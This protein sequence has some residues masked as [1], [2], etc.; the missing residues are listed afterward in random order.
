MYCYFCG[1]EQPQPVKSKCAV[2]G[3]V[4]QLPPSLVT[5]GRAYLLNRLP[6][7]TEAGV[8]DTATAERIREVVGDELDGVAAPPHPLTPATVPARSVAA[9]API[10]VREPAAVRAAAPAP[11]G[12]SF[13]ETFFTPERAPSLL[14]YLGAFLVVV[15]ALIFVNVSGQQISDA[16]RLVLMIVGTLGFLAGGLVCH[17]IPRVAEAG[18]TFLVVG[19]LLVPLDFGAYY[20][21]IARVSPFTSP[22]MWVLGSLVTAGLYGALAIT[23]YGRAYSY[24]FFIASLSALGGFAVLLHLL[25]AWSLV[26]FAALPLAIQLAARIGN[27]RLLRL[28]GP[29]DRPGQFLMFAALV[30]GALGTVVI[31]VSRSLPLNERLAVPALALLVTAYYLA[32]TDR[33]HPRERW[34]AAAGPAAIVF[35]SLVAVD[36]PAQTYGF[37][38]GLLA[39][40]YALIREV[41]DLSGAP[42]PFPMWARDRARYLGYALIA[43]AFLPVA[44]YWRAPF[45][46]A[47]TYVAMA[48][49]LGSLAVWRA[50]P[51]R[52]GPSPL[53]VSGLA[54]VGAAALHIGVIFVLVATGVTRSGTAPFSGLEPR[55]IALGFV[56]IAAVLGAL[57]LIS[58]RRV[59]SLENAVSLAGLASAV[60]VVGLSFR[61]APLATVLA[62]AASVG[63]AIAAVDGRRPPRLWIAA[64]FAAVAA[65]SA[66]RWMQPPEELR[67]LALAA[68]ALLLFAPAYLGR[69][70][71]NA[72]ARVVRE[73]AIAAAL[74]AVGV[75]F[76]FALARPLSVVPWD[77]LVWL[78]T[79]PAFSVFGALAFIEGLH[80]R[81]ERVALFATASFLA[82]VLIVVARLHPAAIEAYTLPAAIY[83]GLAAWGIAR[84]GSRALRADLGL[85]AQLGAAVALLGPTYLWSWERDAVS[86]T[87]VVLAESVILLR[88]ASARGL[89]ELAAVSIGALGLV[90]VRAAAA[91]LALE[92]STAAFGAIT[93]ALVLL[94]PR[95]SW[96]VGDRLRE[97]AEV[98]GVLLLLGP[99]LVRA[100]AFGADALSHGASVL[101]GGAVVVAFGLWSGRRA[102]VATAAA[103]LAA[104]GVLALRDAARAESFVAASGVVVLALV[105]AIP[106]YLPRRLPAIYEMALEILA[107]GLVVSGGIEQ[108]LTA[109]LSGGDGHAARVLA[110]SIVLLAIGLA[111]SRRALA[112]AGLAAVAVM[113]IWIMGDPTARQFHGIAAGA[114][115]IGISL[116]A[117]RYAPR[118][119]SDRA[120][121]GSELLG[122]TLFLAPTLL[123]SWRAPFVPG[124]IIVFFEIALLLAV[125][126]LLR[127]RWLVAG[128]LAVVGLEAIRGTIDVVNRLPNWALF[129]GSGAI[130][131]TAGFVLLL[132]REAWNEWSRRAYA[133]WARL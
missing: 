117:V 1:A 25:P 121:I 16:V 99:P 24:L 40:A 66:G 8:V 39:I 37:V 2:C 88:F 97:A 35:G 100:T 60:L 102:V 124:T 56:P 67:P 73:I 9:V 18:P 15:A 72:F 107:V 30:L 120:L 43:G 119:L 61:E 64:A 76:T 122:A 104:T 19:A 11:K 123:A 10:A 130:L 85:L 22:A 20:A 80:R 21:L 7:L 93:L 71:E 36:A 32:R 53:D 92:S 111:S 50:W 54:M 112:T 95:I 31:A 26:P 59:P 47:T 57:A 116:A 44:A 14:L 17:R 6:D 126:I 38:S 118:V 3:R 49:L 128:A 52:R 129:G 109:R 94:V 68:A 133:W 74:A 75:G 127:R 115:L 89:P 12:P 79:A 58:R 113:A 110:E 86:R 83:L 51:T 4:L 132:K 105:L 96:R 65:V 103:M 77:T 81:S 84:F 41:S 91:P 69:F 106:R 131:L 70:R 13:A 23:A 5:L 46:G 90:V 98:V 87:L 101:A 108:T 82:S 28:V 78:A 45:V 114:A 34:L 33:D 63:A 29:L 42:S 125:G 55:T 48:L 62:T 27:T